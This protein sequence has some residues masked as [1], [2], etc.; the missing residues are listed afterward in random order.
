M[1]SIKEKILNENLNN[2]KKKN[3]NLV[4][5]IDGVIATIVADGNYNNANPITKNINYINKLK[6]AGIRIVLFTRSIFIKNQL[7]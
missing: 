6:K 1:K 4:I 3:D 7:V 2:I 5:D